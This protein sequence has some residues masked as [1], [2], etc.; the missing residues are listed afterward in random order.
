MLPS[1]CQSNLLGH[2]R[3]APCRG[4][5]DRR[6][7]RFMESSICFCHQS[8]F[9]FAP[10]FDGALSQR[11][12]VIGNDEVGI[13]TQ[14]IA[15]PFALRTGAERMVEGKKDGTKARMFARIADRETCAVRLETMADDLDGT[16][17][18]PS[19]NA[20]STASTRRDRLSLPDHQTIEHD[21]ERPAGCE[22]CGTSCRS[23]R[24][25]SALQ[26]GKPA[27]HQRLDET[28]AC[29]GC[30]DGNRK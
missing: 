21:V 4:G 26:S 2:L 19:R 11:L 5:R 25:S 15:E 18:S 7:C 14:N 27:Q 22:G 12:G 6:H 30:R 29:C 9:R 8:P 16:G 20:V 10:R 3:E 1:P 13:V 17:P 28:P 24:S 23:R